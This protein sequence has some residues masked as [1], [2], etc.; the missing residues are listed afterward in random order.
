MD[1]SSLTS[2]L[3][4]NVLDL[5]FSRRR[6]KAGSSTRRMIC[7]MS[8]RILN[9]VNGRTVLN[10]LPPGGA[11]KT[12]NPHAKNLALAW[13]ILLQDFRTISV[14]SVQILAQ[15][16]EQQFWN[17]FNESLLPLSPGDKLSLMNS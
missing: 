16:D 11:N 6:P 14:E 15:Y 5:R 10:Y 4:E 13:D 17:Y 12:Y 2:L 8:D 9:S 1:L 3:R 7:T